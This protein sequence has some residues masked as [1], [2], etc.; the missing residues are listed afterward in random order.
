MGKFIAFLYGSVSYV[1][2]LG[3]FLYSIGFVGNIVVPKSIDSGPEGPFGTALAINVV[4]LLIF[5]IQ[6]NVMARPAFKTWWTRIVPT[7]VERSTFVLLSSL[8]LILLFWQWRPMTGMIWN[9]DQP[10]VVLVLQIIF[11]L[12][13]L[14]V[15]LSTFMINHFDLFGLRQVYLNLRD[16]KYT[17]LAFKKTGL[18]HIVRH[19]LMMGFI[20]AFWA[21]PVMTVGHLLFAGV[22]TVWILF[23]IKLEER[24]LA[25]YHEEY[26]DYKKDTAMVIPIPKAK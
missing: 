23:S 19:P 5:A 11:W 25:T 6:H 18:Y 4:L 24:D 15:L 1:V 9:V 21:A 3:A 7:A 22:T 10:I 20:I 13:W 8:I 26:E 17:M 12:G 14:I 16:Q 2:F